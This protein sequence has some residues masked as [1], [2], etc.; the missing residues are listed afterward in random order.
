MF[1]YLLWIQHQFSSGGLLAKLND[2]SFLEIHQ[3]YAPL[4]RL[5]GTDIF[6]F[7]RTS[8]LCQLYPAKRAN[9]TD[10]DLPC[11]LSLQS[12]VLRLLLGFTTNN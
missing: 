8:S 12:L 11:G 5:A 6:D 9:V 7:H 3:H 10:K 1:S 2:N 4:T